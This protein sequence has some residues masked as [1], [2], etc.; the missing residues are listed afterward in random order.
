M[1]TF[2]RLVNL[3]L[4]IW[5]YGLTGDRTFVLIFRR[6]CFF[7]YYY[8]VAK[9]LRSKLIFII[10]ANKKLYWLF[11]AYKM[12]VKKLIKSYR[13]SRLLDFVVY[14]VA[15]SLWR[16][17]IVQFMHALCCILFCII[18]FYFLMFLINQTYLKF[19]WVILIKINSI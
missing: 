9:N 11:I 3:F 7:K 4:S 6:S 16:F 2:I 12:T 8:I 18:N 10:Q 19:I 13:S 15:F 14:S 5:F 17:C 1:R